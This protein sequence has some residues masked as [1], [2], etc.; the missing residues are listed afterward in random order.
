MQIW[1][2]WLMSLSFLSQFYSSIDCT[3]LK[4]IPDISSVVLFMKY[5]NLFDF[6][7]K[8]TKMTFSVIFFWH[9]FASNPVTQFSRAISWE[10]F[11]QDHYSFFKSCTINSL[12]NATLATASVLTLMVQ[13]ESFISIFSFFFYK[14]KRHL[15]KF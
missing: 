12:K 4:L 15:K 1:K 7:E 3:S 8:Q 9:F 6:L 2:F 14:I 13:F 10:Q 11:P 5:F